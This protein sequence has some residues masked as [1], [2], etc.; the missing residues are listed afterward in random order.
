MKCKHQ[1]LHESKNE[2]NWTKGSI[3]T[4]LSLTPVFRSTENQFGT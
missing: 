4:G 1:T 3:F 2:K